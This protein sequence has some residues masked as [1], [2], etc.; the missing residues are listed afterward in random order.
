M[1][2][3]FLLMA[4]LLFSPLQAVNERSTISRSTQAQRFGNQ[5]T[6]VAVPACPGSAMFSIMPSLSRS[7]CRPEFLDRVD[8]EVDLTNAKV[9][10]AFVR[11]IVHQVGNII[12]SC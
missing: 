8:H 11:R 5:R 1:G 12:G 7:E 4:I 6:A 3:L 9:V 2:A 10:P